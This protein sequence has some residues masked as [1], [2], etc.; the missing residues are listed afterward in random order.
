MMEVIKEGGT[1]RL[2]D[3]L[4]VKMIIRLADKIK[5]AVR[6]DDFFLCD[7]IS[8]KE[9]TQV[10]I[11]ARTNN[12]DDGNVDDNSDE[13]EET[14]PREIE[15]HHCALVNEIEVLGGRNE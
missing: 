9:G 2:R 12:E 3:P 14:D 11:R 8:D 15:K 7:E 13:R 5:P 10:Q 6:C 1:Y 4:S